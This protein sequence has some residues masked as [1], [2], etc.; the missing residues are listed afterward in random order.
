[1]GKE[2]VSF[3]T[4]ARGSTLPRKRETSTLAYK[5]TAKCRRLLIRVRDQ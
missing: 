3:G 5:D 4:P 1:M 2:D